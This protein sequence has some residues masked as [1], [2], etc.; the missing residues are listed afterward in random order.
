MVT[1]DEDF[2]DARMY[3]LG[4]HRGVIQLRVWPTTVEQTQDALGRL[5]DQ[6]PESDWRCNLI[7]V[8]NRKIRVRRPLDS[9]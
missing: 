5:L 2:A 6:L 3:P 9:V 8:D 1:Y 7:I 4:N